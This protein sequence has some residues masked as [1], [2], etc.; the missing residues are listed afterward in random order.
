M[1]KNT[2]MKKA[3]ILFYLFLSLLVSCSKEE[4]EIENTEAFES[5]IIT[6]NKIK[7]NSSFLN[8]V[9]YQ[10]INAINKSTNEIGIFYFENK[11]SSVFKVTSTRGLWYSGGDCATWGTIYTDDVSGVSIFEPAS[12]S[13]Q[14]LMNVCGLSNLSRIKS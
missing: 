8:S 4:I 13:T 2:I 1:E 7:K 11:Q 10:K 9:S 6:N 14:L 12:P 5:E 3:S